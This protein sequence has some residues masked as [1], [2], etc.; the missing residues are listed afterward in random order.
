MTDQKPSDALTT[1][2]R[3]GRIAVIAAASLLVASG[4]GIG[5]YA[6]AQNLTPAVEQTQP[7]AEE[8]EETPTAEPTPNAAPTAYYVVSS[9]S[10]LT[11]GF[12]GTGSTDTDGEIVSYS[13]N[14]G[15]GATGTGATTSHVYG[16]SGSY[17]VTLTVTDD[18]GATA[19]F[20]AVIDVTAP[21]GPPSNEG[22]TY[23]N[24]PPGYPMPRI[25]GT[26]QPDTSACASGT[27][28]TNGSGE[29]VCA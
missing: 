17:T 8:P 29:Q 5:G 12:D 9:V 18:A 16:A 19:A 20:P 21:A 15:D 1:P 13:W 25:P 24:Y 26:D 27:G 7:A 3:R 23:G 11:L 2:P 4:L 10:G 6:V 28:M 22:Y 14:F